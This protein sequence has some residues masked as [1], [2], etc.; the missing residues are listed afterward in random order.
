MTLLSVTAFATALV[1]PWLPLRDQRNR[2]R[3]ER[4]SAMVIVWIVICLAPRFI[5]ELPWLFFL[6]EIRDG[7]Q[8]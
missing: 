6:D 3:S 8:D 7:V 5:W 1:L 2:T 4:V